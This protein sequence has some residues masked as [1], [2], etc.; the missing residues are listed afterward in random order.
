MSGFPLL[1]VAV[2][3][4]VPGYPPLPLVF[5]IF[6]LA[7]KAK[8]ILGLQQLAGKILSRKELGA[9]WGFQRAWFKH[10]AWGLT[11]IA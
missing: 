10:L 1:E 5:G 6:D 8:V 9:G 4:V 2:Y 7:P 3:S 11:Q